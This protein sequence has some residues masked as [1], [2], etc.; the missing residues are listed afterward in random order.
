MSRPA[1]SLLWWLGGIAL[2][3]TSY[4]TLWRTE[5]SEGLSESLGL[6]LRVTTTTV[7]VAL[8]GSLNPWRAKK[9]P[10]KSSQTAE[11]TD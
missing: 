10:E 11:P 9:P 5:W 3:V 6:L 4:L 2:I 1:A 7:L 8:I